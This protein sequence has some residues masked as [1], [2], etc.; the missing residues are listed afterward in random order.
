MIN[1]WPGAVILEQ[2]DTEYQR[3][4]RRLIDAGYGPGF[5]MYMH[6]EERAPYGLNRF[7]HAFKHIVTRKYVRV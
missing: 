1:A 4:W 7:V 5:Y 3:A 6:S 2:E